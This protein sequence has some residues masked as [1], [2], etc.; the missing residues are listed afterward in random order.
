[1]CFQSKM[2]K[3]KKLV[4]IQ[5]ASFFILCHAVLFG[6]ALC[7]SCITFPCVGRVVFFFICLSTPT[8]FWKLRFTLE[9]YLPT[10]VNEWRI[11]KPLSN[12]RLCDHSQNH[13]NTKWYSVCRMPFA[14]FDTKPWINTKR[15][16]KFI[17]I[18]HW[19]KN[20]KGKENRARNNMHRRK[21]ENCCSHH[22]V[23]DAENTRI[24]GKK[25]L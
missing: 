5:I 1:M 2:Q 20:R 11:K 21:K 16:K 24:E 14:F 12:A 17:L 7:F 10:K 22:N 13:N 4:Y 18:I 23:K 3:Q 19:T 25:T 9:I 8:P 6:S 15:K